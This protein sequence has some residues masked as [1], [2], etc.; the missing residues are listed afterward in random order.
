MPYKLC[1]DLCGYA[2]EKCVSFEGEKN[3]DEL[4]NLVSQKTGLTEGKARLAVDVVVSYLKEKLPAPIADQ[5]E[6]TLIG[7][8]FVGKAGELAK[9]VGGMF[10]KK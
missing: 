5:V 4:I 9:G 7:E 1:D 6:K 2:G 8:S 3:M 10:G